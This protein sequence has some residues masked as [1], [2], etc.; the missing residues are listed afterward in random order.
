[1]EGKSLSQPG[2][3]AERKGRKFSLFNGGKV[4]LPRRRWGEEDT[5]IRKTYDV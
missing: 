5:Y 4:R 2:R 3:K 1:M